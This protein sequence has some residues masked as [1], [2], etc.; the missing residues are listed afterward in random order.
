[1]LNAAP[2]WK[3]SNPKWRNRVFA[4]ATLGHG[5]LQSAAIG[6][7]QPLPKARRLTFRAGAA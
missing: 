2:E 4:E 7:R 1:M 6:M 3:A 5:Q